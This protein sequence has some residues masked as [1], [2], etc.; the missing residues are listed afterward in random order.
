[1][2]D[3][4]LFNSFFDVIST[5]SDYK[6]VAFQDNSNC[7][8]QLTL[9]TK[10]E[11]IFINTT[12]DSAT[13]W[14][15]L[16]SK[17][18]IPI[19]N[20]IDKQ[21]YEAIC[22]PMDSIGEQGWKFLIKPVDLVAICKSTRLI[23][24]KIFDHTEEMAKLGSWRLEYKTKNIEWSKQVYKS[25]G[26][27]EDSYTP[28]ME[29]YMI[30]V[31]PDDLI[32][33]Q[34][35]REKFLQSKLPYKEEVR[36][37]QP[38]GSYRW[39]LIHGFPVVVNGEV[40]AVEGTNFDIHEKKMYELQLKESLDVQSKLIDE[41]KSS[42]L[43]IYALINNTKDFIW[44]VN[45]NYEVTVSNDSF[46]FAFK[47]A[48]NKDLKIGRYILE[49]LPINF[50]NIW[51]SKYNKTFAGEIWSEEL[52][53]NGYIL[54]ISYNPILDAEGKVVGAS[55]FSREITARK[56][57]QQSLEAAFE[58]ESKLNEELAAREEELNQNIDY[59]NKL[60][61]NITKQEAQLAAV[62]N[63]TTDIIVSVNKELEVTEYNQAYS[64][65][66]AATMNINVVRSGKL[67][68]YTGADQWS[69]TTECL[70]KVFL[71]E[72]VTV[73]MSY[74]A[75]ATHTIYLSVLYAPIFG[76]DK[77]VNGAT[78]IA[79]N[80]TDAKEAELQVVALNKQMAEYKLMA[81]RSVMNPH[82][83]FNS[84][85]SIQYFIL[86]ND[87]NQAT[88]YLS[89]FSK[90]IRNVLDSSLKNTL[91]L[92]TELQILRH[93]LE[94]EVLRFENKFTYQISLEDGVDEE[95]IAIPSLLIQP[96][97]ENAII[98]GLTNNFDSG[99]LKIEIK[100]LD[101]SQLL[102]IIEDNGIG[103]EEAIKLKAN[104]F[105]PHQSYG[106]LVT[107]ER[108]DIINQTSDVSVLI[109]DLYDGSKATGTR[110]EIKIG[111]APL[112]I[113]S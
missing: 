15:K 22:L 58:K 82:F 18:W 61:E 92:K 68:D 9:G 100:K 56:L 54:E 48:F 38:D 11:D 67:Q 49:D 26:L 77:E 112:D 98:H 20:I 28:S 17:K 64:A 53:S 10:L 107:K 34:Q 81:L 47:K 83:I 51:L 109:T 23:S 29:T 27:S 73:M 37:K 39:F 90:L 103:R 30:L 36:L 94:L 75:T 84:L 111:I 42:E 71:G 14:M 41:I 8:S 16:A 96:Y 76:S 31:H 52:D 104:S 110:V 12:S 5:D 70:D 3:N 60:I 88:N 101:D 113:L 63:S 85:N 25:F 108:L 99:F 80:V 2:L 105:V 55:V 91:D 78:I 93:Y 35:N 57:A 72:V 46:K 19:E 33:Q 97:V 43:E 13:Q 89:V 66:I 4:V 7:S 32:V 40:V 79:R 50:V 44:A 62:I 65:T 86:K 74:P 69:F 106:M 6:I 21:I 102:V 24:K 59:Q 45:L 87:R 1:M 95:H